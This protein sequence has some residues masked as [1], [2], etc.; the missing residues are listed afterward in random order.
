MCV[1]GGGKRGEGR[2]CAAVTIEVKEKMDGE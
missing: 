1:W 2:V